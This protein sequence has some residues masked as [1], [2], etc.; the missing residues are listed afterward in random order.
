MNCKHCEAPNTEGWFYCRTC[1]ERASSRKFTNVMFMRSEAGKRT[2]IE[3]STMS[4]DAHIDK[5]N[6][7]K[8]ARQAKVWQDRVRQAGI[9]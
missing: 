9:N 5:V 2:D 4:M 8:K 7:D 3:F 6:K 1:G